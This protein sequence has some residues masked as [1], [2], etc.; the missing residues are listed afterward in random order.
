VSIYPKG[1]FS[2]EAGANLRFDRGEKEV[3]TYRPCDRGRALIK[4]Q[5]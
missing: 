5:V 1:A 3:S 4:T 2:K